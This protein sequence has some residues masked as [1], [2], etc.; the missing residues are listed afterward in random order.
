MREYV[1]YVCIVLDK[2]TN[3]DKLEN[4]LSANGYS[5]GI[6]KKQNLLFVFIEEVEYVETILQDRGIIYFV[7]V[8]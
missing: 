1:E 6:D 8:Y 7:R 5:V 3:L 2:G 4:H